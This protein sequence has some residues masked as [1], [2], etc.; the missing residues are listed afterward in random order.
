MARRYPG[1]RRRWTGLERPSTRSL[2]S[3][4][5]DEAVLCVTI[6]S[7]ILSKGR[8]ARVE[9]RTIGALLQQRER[10]MESAVSGDLVA[11]KRG[12]LAAVV[13]ERSVQ[14]TRAI[15]ECRFRPRRAPKP[16]GCVSRHVGEQLLPAAPWRQRRS[17]VRAKLAELARI[18]VANHGPPR[19]QPVAKRI[20][21]GGGL[22]RGC[23]RPRALQ[24]VAAIGGDLSGAG[25]RLASELRRTRGAYIVAYDS[26]SA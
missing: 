9:G 13:R 7:F 17:H 22:A 21:A 16:P 19:G 11:L 4:A 6:I 10:T 12:Q 8:K 20:P 14:R 25:H 3:L 18:L 23:P 15:E 26:S 2:W 1:T 5:Q 24:G